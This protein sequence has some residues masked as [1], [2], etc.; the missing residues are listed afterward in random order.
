MAKLAF[1]LIIVPTLPENVFK[2][3]FILFTYAVVISRLSNLGALESIAL[4]VQGIKK[5]AEVFLCFWI[6]ILFVS[7]GLYFLSLAYEM[8]VV[9]AVGLCMASASILA[10]CLRTIKHEYFEIL[11]NLPWVVFFIVCMQSDIHDEYELLRIM[12]YSYLLVQL[13]V[14]FMC[15]SFWPGIISL[16]GLKASTL[17]VIKNIRVGIGFQISSVNQMLM[18]RGP[19]LA[20]E[21][22]GISVVTDTIAMAVSLLEAG[23]QLFMVPVNRRYSEICKRKNNS[24]FTSGLVNTLCYIVV[25]LMG[26]I[27]LHQFSDVFKQHLGEDLFAVPME[28]WVAI[29]LILAA[30]L[31]YTEAKNIVIKESGI[32]QVLKIE[33]LLTSLLI[34][35]A[36]AWQLLFGNIA[37]IASLFLLVSVYWASRISKR[38]K[39][40][41][42]D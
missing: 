36:C 40:L 25:C 29:I 8:V 41:D 42:I 16:Q 26:L 22:L 13:A 31:I 33:V 38:Y 9:L 34:V 21:F 6:V 27:I 28:L 17:S 30:I 2:G 1:L 15:F 12:F 23:W 20:P 10:G 11:I 7:L 37:T 19:L 5:R 18:I 4:D 14:S 35:S 3:Y 32:W 39:A 24:F